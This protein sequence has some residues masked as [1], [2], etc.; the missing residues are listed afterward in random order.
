M[1]GALDLPQLDFGISKF[2]ETRLWTIIFPGDSCKSKRVQETL[3]KLG[4]Q[5]AKVRHNSA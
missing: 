4:F 5:A 1:L 2:L 3:Q